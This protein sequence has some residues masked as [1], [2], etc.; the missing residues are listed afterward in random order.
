MDTYLFSGAILPERAQLQLQNAHRFTHLSSGVTGSIHISV[1]CNQLA[2]WVTSEGH[3]WDIFDLRNIVKT[4]VQNQ[5][6][7]VGY[8]VGYAYDVEITRVLCP[9]KGIDHV[10]GIDIPCLASRNIGLDLQPALAT[11]ERKSYGPN[12][13]FLHRCFT[14]LCFA[15]KHADDTGFYCYRAIESLF[16]HCAAVH[17]LSQSS[18]P[19]RWAKFREVSS[20]DEATLYL[21]KE[22][23]DPLRHGEVTS[24]GDENR[25]QLFTST[26]D[27]VDGYLKSVVEVHENLG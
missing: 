3:D 9:V 15:M 12:G 5:I 25:V 26:W 7:M 2:V 1:L 14:D 18:K 20:C 27:V 10:F 23:A 4:S 13:M 19:V 11:L 22:A 24:C 17:G 21:I 16:H 6:A 8:L